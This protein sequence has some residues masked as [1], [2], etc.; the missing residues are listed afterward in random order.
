M[1]ELDNSEQVFLTGAEVSKI[2]GLSKQTLLKL[3]KVG[4]LDTY[5]SGNS[6]VV[7]CAENVKAFLQ[8]RVP[9]KQQNNQ[10]GE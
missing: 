6:R 3:R 5:T 7:Y 4:A 8:S 10:S 1:S 9:T 2:L